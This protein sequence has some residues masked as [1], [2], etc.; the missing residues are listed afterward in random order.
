MLT[1]LLNRLR[2]ADNSISN[3]N[4][5]I[6]KLDQQKEKLIIENTELEKEKENIKNEIKKQKLLEVNI[7]EVFQELQK[8]L[9]HY[10]GCYC[11]QSI[12]RDVKI[13]SKTLDRVKQIIKEQNRNLYVCF[14]FVSFSGHNFYD[15]D[16]RYPIKDIRMENGK[17]LVNYLV[18][19]D[20]DVVVHKNAQD[21][22]LINIDIDDPLMKDLLFNHAVRNYILNKEQNKTQQKN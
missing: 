15:F 4:E 8:I 9:N 5:E 18:V 2:D 21:K 20:N 6:L 1:K 22:I 11:V 19:E 14:Q 17:K 10:E 13:N 12:F 7:F 3:N 16:L